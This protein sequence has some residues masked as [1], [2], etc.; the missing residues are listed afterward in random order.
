MFAEV[1]AKGS[2]RRGVS[3]TTKINITNRIS[4]QHL[5]IYYW[6]NVEKIKIL[7]Y[8]TRQLFRQFR[9]DQFISKL[10]RDTH[11]Y[12]RA[13]GNGAETTFFIA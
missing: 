13:F 6:S 12:C 3:W 10:S 9:S 8:V 11:T 2:E 7:R 4:Y 1:L 5:L